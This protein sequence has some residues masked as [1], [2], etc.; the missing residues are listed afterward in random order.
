MK[1]NVTLKPSQEYINVSIKNITLYYYKIKHSKNI[2]I[3]SI[4][5]IKYLLSYKHISRGHISP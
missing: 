5:I 4:I 3:I 1:K 2:Y